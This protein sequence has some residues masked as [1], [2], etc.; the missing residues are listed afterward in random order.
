VIV[1]IIGSMITGAPRQ[2]R[3]GLGQRRLDLGEERRQ[4]SGL[5]DEAVGRIRRRLLER[6]RIRRRARG[7]RE[8]REGEDRACE[9]ADHLHSRLKKSVSAGVIFSSDAFCRI[10]VQRVWRSSG[11]V[12]TIGA[13]ATAAAVAAAEVAGRDAGG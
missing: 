10:S 5:R 11:V 2:L 7:E 4:L 6:L 1:S 12:T 13:V 9:R 3:V 8:R